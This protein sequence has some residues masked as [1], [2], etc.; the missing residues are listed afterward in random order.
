MRERDGLRGSLDGRLQRPCA[1]YS[2]ETVAEGG[3]C[4]LVFEDLHWADDG[5][6]DWAATV[7]DRVLMGRTGIGAKSLEW[8]RSQRPVAKEMPMDGRGEITL[9][10]D[11]ARKVFDTAVDSMD[12]GSGFLDHESSKPEK[13]DAQIVEIVQHVALNTWTNYLNSVA[14]TVMS[15]AP[16]RSYAACAR[17]CK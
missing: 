5:L 12:F 8:I 14:G 15:E 10:L 16:L 9:P 7:P 6:L 1:P 2:V 4:V 3:P 11:T 13:L 17:P